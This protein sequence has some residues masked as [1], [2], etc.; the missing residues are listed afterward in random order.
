L[1]EA[2][3]LEELQEQARI[4]LK[5]ET[6]RLEKQEQAGVK[7]EKQA[8]VERLKKQKQARAEA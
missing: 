4:I 8:E 6:E 3:R 7:A 5:A 2:M 1:V